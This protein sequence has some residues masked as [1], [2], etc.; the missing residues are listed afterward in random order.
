MKSGLCQFRPQQRQAALQRL[1]HDERVVRAAAS[2]LLAP[3]RVHLL[4]TLHQ[5]TVE[6]ELFLDRIR[7]R[8]RLVRRGD[9]VNISLI[10]YRVGMAA[11]QF[12]QCRIR[13]FTEK[14]LILVPI[15]VTHDT[16]I[17]QSCAIVNTATL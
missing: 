11:D 6:H 9:A 1:T 12:C 3:Q 5:G 8:G 14:M 4:D 7:R 15:N 2:Q 16:S 10:G 17:T 13:E